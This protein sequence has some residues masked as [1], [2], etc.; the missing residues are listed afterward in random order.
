MSEK[1]R[2]VAQIVT[3]TKSNYILCV[4]SL[5]LAAPK[6]ELRN[7]A[8]FESKGQKDTGILRKKVILQRNSVYFL[9]Y[10]RTDGRRGHEESKKIFAK[11]TKKG[12][13]R[14]KTES[15]VYFAFGKVAAHLRPII[16]VQRN[17]GVRGLASRGH[18]RAVM[19]TPLLG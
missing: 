5:Y 9:K 12:Y 11:L 17:V 7:A 1:K 8:N 10:G 14:A 16:A 4:A 13:E 15:R 6:T 3:Y 2:R 18:Q 19:R